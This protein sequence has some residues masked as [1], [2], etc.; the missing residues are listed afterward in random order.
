MKTF[1]GR[2]LAA[3]TMS[4]SISCSSVIATLRAETPRG[5]YVIGDTPRKW[6]ESVEGQSVS[7]ATEI[8]VFA[9]G[10]RILMNIRVKNVGYGN[11]K[12]R[13]DGYMRAQFIFSVDLK[14]ADGKPVPLTLEG[15]K[16][17]HDEAERGKG[18]F[19]GTGLRHGEELSFGSVVLTTLYDL[20]RA[21]KYIASAR[22][23]VVKD[24]GGY[25]KTDAVSNILEFSVSEPN[26]PPIQKLE[27]QIPGRPYLMIIPAFDAAHGR[28][29]EAA[30]AIVKV[31]GGATADL[32]E[33]VEARC[34]N[35][36]VLQSAI[37]LGIAPK[38]A[39][40]SL[41][42]A[43]D[44]KAGRSDN[45]RAGQPCWGLYPAKEALV[46][47]GGPAVA[48][49]TAALGGE[50]DANR[51]KLMVGV[52]RDALGSDVAE[53]VLKKAADSSPDIKKANYDQARRELNAGGL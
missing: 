40:P 25:A 31:F 51:R 7:I 26:G 27:E 32:I 42:A 15:Q 18:S 53:S 35:E 43:I 38:V 39:V 11:L 45:Y 9:S 6:G 13:Y 2:I 5:L 3:V 46:K 28:A 30:E 36:A 17:L 10:D 50:E 34:D 44:F 37:F 24:G 8:P 23:K 47:I 21:G 48:P 49:I 12:V 16:E 22:M 20:S 19:R 1:R 14:F 41:L 52:L 4:V 29:D 33:Q